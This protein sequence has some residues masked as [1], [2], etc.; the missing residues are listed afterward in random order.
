[1]HHKIDSA[2]ELFNFFWMSKQVEIRQ[3]NSLIFKNQDFVHLHFIF[4]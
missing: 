1:M 4:D 3:K 2:I